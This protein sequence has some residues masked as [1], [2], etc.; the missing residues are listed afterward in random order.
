MRRHR[1]FEST[2]LIPSLPCDH[3]GQGRP[4]GVYGSKAD[5]IPKG[6]KT[7]GTLA[8]G[9]EAMGIDWMPWSKLVLSIPPAYTEYIGGHLMQV[10]L[11]KDLT[12]GFPEGILTI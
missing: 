12:T 1:Q 10:V 2:F 6:G 11:A 9:Q 8:E 3:K 4:V 5:D 7:A